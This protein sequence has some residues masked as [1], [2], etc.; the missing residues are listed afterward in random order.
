MV[1]FSVFPL[2]FVLPS[3]L[4][5]I[6]PVS[7]TPTTTYRTCNYILHSLRPLLKAFCSS[8]S[9]STLSTLSYRRAE[10]IVLYITFRQVTG[11]KFS[12]KVP[13]FP[14]GI[15]TVLPSWNNAG[16]LSSPSSKWQ[17]QFFVSEVSLGNC[18]HPI[19]VSNQNFP[20]ALLPY[21]LHPWSC[22]SGTSGAA[23]TFCVS[24]THCFRTGYFWLNDPSTPQTPF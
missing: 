9:R 17:K 3:Q 18:L 22:S 23:I 15:I 8:W 10:V 24:R 20:T 21:C 11:L 5:L 7:H 6:L 1:A 13:P 19:T 2:Y 12:S 4:Y 16:T 14:L